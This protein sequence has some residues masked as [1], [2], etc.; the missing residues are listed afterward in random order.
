MFDL[1]QIDFS[2]GKLNG[3]E[4]MILDKDNRVDRIIKAFCKRWDSSCDPNVLIDDIL[5]E[6]NIDEDDLSDNEVNCLNR[7]LNKIVN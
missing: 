3:I 7:K 2:D 5:F 6:E 1:G 4:A